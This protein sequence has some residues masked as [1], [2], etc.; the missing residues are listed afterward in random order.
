VP[1][2]NIQN[3]TEVLQK[4][5]LTQSDIVRVFNDDECALDGLADN[6]ETFRL[7]IIKKNGTEILLGDMPPDAVFSIR[8]RSIKFEP[9]ADSY[10]YIDI[11]SAN[12]PIKGRGGI[13]LNGSAIN[14]ARFSP[15]INSPGVGVVISGTASVQYIQAIRYNETGRGGSIVGGSGVNEYKES[16][17]YFETASGGV[18]IGSNNTYY[19]R[20]FDRTPVTGYGVECSGQATVSMN[21]ME[22]V[23]NTNLGASKSAYIVP[24]GTVDI[25]VHW[26]DGTSST[27]NTAGVVIH[28]YTDHGI[29]N[30]IIQGTMTGYGFD[31]QDF[32]GQSPYVNNLTRVVRFGKTGLTDMSYAF[33]GASNLT[34]VSVDFPTTV[35]NLSYCFKAA[36][37]LNHQNLLLWDVSNVTNMSG[38]F[39]KAVAF[40]QDLSSWDVSNV[41]NMSHMFEGD[42]YAEQSAFNQPLNSWDVSKVTDMSSMFL[43]ALAFNQPLNSWNISN[44]TSTANMFGGALV[45]DQDLSSWNTSKVTNMSGMFGGCFVFNQPLNSWDVSKVTDMSSMFDYAKEFNQP[46]DSWNVSL[47]NNMNRMFAYAPKFN[48]S[49]NSWQVG[50]VQNMGIMFAGATV[51]DGNITSWNTSNVTIMQEMFGNAKEFNQ[52]ISSWNVSNVIDMGYMFRSASKFNQPIG[53]WNVSNVIAMNSMFWLTTVFNQPLNTWNV[54]KVISFAFMFYGSKFNQPLDN[55]NTSSCESFV[56]MFEGDQF[57]QDVSMWDFT[58]IGPHIDGYL[59]NLDP[60]YGFFSS[61]MSVSNMNNVLVNWDTNKNS[62]PVNLRMGY[63][64]QTPTGAG[65]TAKTSLETN[66]GWN[67]T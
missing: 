24:K 58:K 17:K 49:L 20:L 52:N 64:P 33:D 62:L 14:R 55:W 50:N 8:F 44:V 25:T 2:K 1:S 48:Q 22:F 45:F 13:T 46:L 67:F 7:F 16:Q 30:V 40:N 19:G 12:P 41:T 18:L 56:R 5:N 39:S 43:G 26:G 28:S 63:L 36:S 15:L 11:T 59:S 66:K 61:A 37:K 60:L 34:D 23:F 47:V 21:V 31:F 57:D 32:Y 38:M 3:R 4:F 10:S 27:V 42:T 29:Y 35:T 65:A 53:S 51:F 9:E 6:N 54:S